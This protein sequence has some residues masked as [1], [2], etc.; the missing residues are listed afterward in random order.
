MWGFYTRDLVYAVLA[1]KNKDPLL[2]DKIGDAKLKQY[3][4]KSATKAKT[5]KPAPPAPA[6]TPSTP[7]LTPTPTSTRT[8]GDY[9]QECCPDASGKKTICYEGECQNGMCIHC[10]YKGEPCCREGADKGYCIHSGVKCDGGICRVET[11]D[12]GHI[13]MR[14]CNY[15]EG[16]VCYT[17]VLDK[18]DTIC[19][20]CGDYEQPCCQYTD[21]PCDYGECRTPD[22]KKKVGYPYVG[23]I[24]KRVDATATPTPSG[25][26]G[27]GKPCC[28]AGRACRSYPSGLDQECVGGICRITE[29]TCRAYCLKT[30]GPD[31]TSQVVG[32]SCKCKKKDL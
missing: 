6:P 2:C 7:T 22:G 14:P 5:K 24:C 21:Y 19:R 26:G 16:P 20:A 25:C 27:Y 4:I 11:E 31:F 17:G 10:G 18:A 29:K 8:C 3:C 15:G 32:S 23:G 12:C 30:Y 28:K 13:G 1:K 9:G